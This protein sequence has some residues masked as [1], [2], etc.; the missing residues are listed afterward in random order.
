MKSRPGA[1]YTVDATE[2]ERITLEMPW[3][4][5]T[6]TLQHRAK[7]IGNAP[8]GSAVVRLAD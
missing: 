8:R 5:F 1:S 7:F 4:G 6:C 3:T 2:P